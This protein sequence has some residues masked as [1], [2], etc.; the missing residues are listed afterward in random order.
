[1]NG[2]LSAVRSQVAQSCIVN[3]C[4][5]DGCSVSLPGNSRNRVVVDCDGEGS[6]FGAN[7][8][9]CD[10]LLFEETDSGTGRA[11][12]IELKSGGIK[13]S[14][15][16]RELQAGAAMVENLI[17]PRTGLRFLPLIASG[18]VPKGEK[19]AIKKVRIRFRGKPVRI[20][21]IRCGNPLPSG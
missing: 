2:L 9:K 15:A 4:N 18:N 1:M 3:R 8:A 11:V 13:A 20:S 14:D 21:R 7:Q 6:P 10:Y 12:P 19:A 17:P 16:I 5:R